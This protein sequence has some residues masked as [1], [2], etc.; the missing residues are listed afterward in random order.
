M[1]I[2]AFALSLFTAILSAVQGLLEAHAAEWG[3]RWAALWSPGLVTS[4]ALLGLIGGGM[5]LTRRERAPF[6]LAI[7]AALCALAFFGGAGNAAIWAVLYLVAALLARLDMNALRRGGRV[8]LAANAGLPRP[9]VPRVLRAIHFFL[10]A[11]LD[12]EQTFQFLHEE[13]LRVMESLTGVE[14]GA[15]VRRAFLLLE[16][17]DFARADQYLERALTQDPEN[18]RAYL[19]KLMV[20][21]RIHRPEELGDGT[22]SFEE[23]RCFQRALQFA[24]EEERVRLAG[25]VQAQRALVDQIREAEMEELEGRYERALVLRAEARTEEDFAELTDL[26]DSLGSYKDAEALAAE[27]A[28]DAEREVRYQRALDLMAEARTEEDFAAL[29][30]LLDSLGHYKDA[31]VLV[32]EVHLERRY[33]AAL[34]MKDRARTEEEFEDAAVLFDALEGFR[35]ADEMSVEARRLAREARRALRA[36]IARREVLMRWS[37]RALCVVALACFFAFG[38]GRWL[39]GL[40]GYVPA[41]EIATPPPAERPHTEAPAAPQPIAPIQDAPSET[42]PVRDEAPPPLPAILPPAPPTPPIVPPAPPALETSHQRHE[43]GLSSNNVAA[44]EQDDPVVGGF[45]T[46]GDPPAAPISQDAPPR[47]PAQVP[48]LVTGNKVNLRT[49]PSLSARILTK[50]A[51]GEPL[52]ST[53]TRTGSDGQTWHCV[54]TDKGLEGWISGRYVRRR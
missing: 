49:E 14:T 8:A 46:W 29:T 54:R 30:D 45:M 24:G 40:F 18:S 16:D 13:P 52:E 4:A 31:E 10:E 41:G 2:V 28:Q 21:R 20:E 32:E 25:Y 12:E 34:A 26:L 6:L 23:D 17:G 39:A 47:P 44:L 42:E 11:P 38:G 53:E 9:A 35:D 48:L 43:E 7:N 33:A 51:R 1:N 50:L 27:V 5:A 19:G 36:S 15:L 22:A 3:A 37:F